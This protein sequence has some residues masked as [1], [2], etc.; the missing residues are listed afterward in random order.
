MIQNTSQYMASFTNWCN[1]QHRN[2]GP[3][4]YRQGQI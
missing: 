1:E 4:K 3:R 2:F